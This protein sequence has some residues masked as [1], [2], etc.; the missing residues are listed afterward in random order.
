MAGNAETG[1]IGWIDITVDDAKGLKDFYAKVVGWQPEGVSMGDYSD[2]NMKMP[3]SGVPAAGI[4]H[5]L[6]SN[7][8]L[9]S[10]WLIYIVVEDVAESAKVC[11]DNGGKV[12]V[13]PRPL[14]GGSFCVIEDPGGAVAALYQPP[15]K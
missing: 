9:P 6:G 5:A 14:S 1:S 4:C 10:Q 12:I 8:G 13:Q 2:F 3:G 11:T 15:A 7:V